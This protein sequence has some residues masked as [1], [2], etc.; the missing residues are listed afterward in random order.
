MLGLNSPQ[1][2]HRFQRFVGNFDEHQCISVSVLATQIDFM[3]FIAILRLDSGRRLSPVHSAIFLSNNFK[4]LVT[5]FEL[6][7]YSSQTRAKCKRN[8]GGDFYENFT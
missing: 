7:P 6:I 3:W 2:L 1:I 4:N 8:K 5:I